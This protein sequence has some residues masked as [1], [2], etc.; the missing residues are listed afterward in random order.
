MLH[1]GKV[2]INKKSINSTPVLPVLHLERGMVLI[3]ALLFLALMSSLIIIAMR[4]SQLEL[5]MTQHYQERL[6][7][8]LAAENALSEA[9]KSLQ[10]NEKITEGKT[11]NGVFQ[12]ELLSGNDCERNYLLK[13]TGQMLQ[14]KVHIVAEYQQSYPSCGGY[15]K[16]LWWHIF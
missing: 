2:K 5:K 1:Y 10:N 16:Q 11:T 4:N 6:Q 12:I 8:F 13:S 14:A 3:L 7:A 9:K 15:T